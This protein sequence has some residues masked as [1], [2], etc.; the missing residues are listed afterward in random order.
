MYS[1]RKTPG[2]ICRR[3]RRGSDSR[4]ETRSVPDLNTT[5]PSRTYEAVSTW[6][7]QRVG[8]GRRTPC[9]S[10]D[11]SP[12][13]TSHAICAVVSEGS[14]AC[15][16]GALGDMGRVQLREDLN[17]LLDVFNLVLC[18]LEIDNLDSDGSLRSFVVATQ[19]LSVKSKESKSADPL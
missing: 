4:A 19:L 1:S 8:M 7:P 6:R 16:S 9:R 5:R 11:W 18:A 12:S 15:M 2:F 13:S 3:V 17:L 14:I 10:I